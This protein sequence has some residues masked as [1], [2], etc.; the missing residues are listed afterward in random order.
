MIISDLQRELMALREELEAKERLLKTLQER[1]GLQN[2][3]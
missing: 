3:G 2:S 1:A